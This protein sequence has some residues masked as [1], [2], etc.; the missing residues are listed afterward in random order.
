MYIMIEQKSK[1]HEKK[2]KNCLEKN[3]QK[4]VNGKQ[5]RQTKK[6]EKHDERKEQQE[7]GS[8]K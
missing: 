8:P 3:D 5:I 7:D 4:T 1:H 6:A 2:S